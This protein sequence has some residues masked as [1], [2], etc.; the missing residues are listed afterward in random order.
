MNSEN[1]IHTEEI[2][3][4]RVAHMFLE[5]IAESPANKLSTQELAALS[6]SSSSLA[7][8][9]RDIAL[10]ILHA[11][12]NNIN[13]EGGDSQIR[14]IT[15]IQQMQRD[16]SIQLEKSDG[17]T[18][19]ILRNLSPEPVTISGTI[20]RLRQEQILAVGAALTSL[21]R[22]S[23]PVTPEEITEE[24]RRTC[25]DAGILNL[26]RYN[27]QIVHPY[28]YWG[29]QRISRTEYEHSKAV[30]RHLSM[31]PYRPSTGG[32]YGTM[33][34][35]LSGARAGFQAISFHGADY[36]SFTQPHIIENEP[37]NPHVNKIVMLRNMEQRLEAF[38]RANLGIVIGPGGIG[39][40][41]ELLYAVAVLLDPKNEGHESAILLTGPD[42]EY[43]RMILTFLQNILDK[44]SFD[45]VKKKIMVSY[46]PGTEHRSASMLHT[47]ITQRT[48]PFRNENGISTSWDYKLHIAPDLQ[49]FIEPS[50]DAASTLT[51]NQDVGADK[52][53]SEIRRFLTY[54]TWGAVSETGNKAI[55]EYGPLTFHAD[56]KTKD[57]L[58]VL[59]AEFQ[60]A[61]RFNFRDQER[62]VIQFA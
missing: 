25:V 13:N 10:A 47:Q 27:D 26:Q 35:P 8:E 33:K 21:H 2:Q 53:I 11:N 54:V 34:A 17:R 58:N 40:L 3:P 6:L 44:E 57:A 28:T 51:L 32:G 15:E 55:D 5:P 38:V 62:N 30:G 19:M 41:E 60:A 12:G 20:P 36:L 16:F 48:L 4:E 14:M 61:K 56:T 59:L 39:T 49:L 37:P 23:S 22:V 18:A 43:G 52:L 9:F 42:E 45:T 7:E 1:P 24:V 31:V 29:G 50:H 46:G